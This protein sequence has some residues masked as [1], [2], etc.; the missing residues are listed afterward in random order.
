MILSRSVLSKLIS[1]FHV[2][3]QYYAKVYRPL[4][5]VLMAIEVERFIPAFILG[6]LTLNKSFLINNKKQTQMFST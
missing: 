6:Q 1:H 5:E 2:F 4:Y 3:R